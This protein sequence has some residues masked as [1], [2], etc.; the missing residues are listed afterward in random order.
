MLYDAHNHLQDAWLMPHRA[1]MWA[2]LARLPLRRAVVNGTCENDWADV[3]ALGREHAFILPSYGLHPWYAG[4]ATPHWRD[5]L[6][7]HLDQSR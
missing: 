5:A 3:A 4:N 2:D 1:Q 6:Q 7:R